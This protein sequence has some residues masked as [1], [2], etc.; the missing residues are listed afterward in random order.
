M[1]VNKLHIFFFYVISNTV[2][3]SCPSVWYFR[4]MINI[5]IN[6][7]T[8]ERGTSHAGKYT[9]CLINVEPQGKILNW[10]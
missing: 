10:L 9:E 8:A 6:W 5:I 4:F 3:Y 2:R 7:M 1:S